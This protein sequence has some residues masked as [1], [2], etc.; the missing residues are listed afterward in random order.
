[1]LGLQLGGWSLSMTGK[2]SPHNV[3]DPLKSPAFFAM[4]EAKRKLRQFL[5]PD[6]RYDHDILTRV[7]TTTATSNGLTVVVDEGCPLELSYQRH[8]ESICTILRSRLLQA[9]ASGTASPAD[10]T[11]EGIT[12][13]FVC[14]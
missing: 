5:I 6:S 9:F 2:I 10:R 13:L 3:V 7:E 14:Y 1:M 11:P 12:L 8:I 4:S